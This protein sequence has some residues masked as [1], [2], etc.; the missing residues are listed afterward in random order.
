MTHKHM[1]IIAIAVILSLL[2]AISLSI[3]SKV[4]EDEP[5]DGY[6]YVLNNG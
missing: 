4:E 2:W 3:E 6:I 1:I 5:E